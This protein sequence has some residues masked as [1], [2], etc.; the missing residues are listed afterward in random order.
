MNISVTTKRSSSKFKLCSLWV[1]RGNLEKTS[2]EISSVALLSPACLFF[3]SDTTKIGVRDYLSKFSPILTNIKILETNSRQARNHKQYIMHASLTTLVKK[4][5]FYKAGYNSPWS[6]WIERSPRSVLCG[7]LVSYV[8]AN[9][10]E[11]HY[12]SKCLCFQFPHQ[13]EW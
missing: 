9:Y 6:F 5:A 7:L 8:A 4:N 11:C 10:E 2:A 13:F 12:P 3:L 1:F